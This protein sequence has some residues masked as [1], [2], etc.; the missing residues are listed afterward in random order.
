MK[1]RNKGRTI[2]LNAL[3]VD[4]GGRFSSFFWKRPF[5]T[6]TNCGVYFTLIQ[7]WL[8]WNFN[9]KSLKIFLPRLVKLDRSH[10]SY[11]W[12]SSI[13]KIHQLLADGS[14]WKS[15][16]IVC[17][18]KYNLLS[19]ASAKHSRKWPQITSKDDGDRRQSGAAAPV[20]HV[21]KRRHV[22]MLCT[23][24]SHN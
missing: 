8:I 13:R 3:I 10:P 15:S 7:R 12:H 2:H 16:A 19:L 21:A 6:H 1:T 14:T 5:S 4:I 11:L 17:S 9:V 24:S 23:R 22:G 18:A 20:V